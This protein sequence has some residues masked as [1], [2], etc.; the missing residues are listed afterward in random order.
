MCPHSARRLPNRGKNTRKPLYTHHAFT[1]AYRQDSTS[2]GSQ[3]ALPIPMSESETRRTWH[4]IARRTR[5]MINFAWWLDCFTPLLIVFSTLAAGIV[6]YL[7]STVGLFPAPWMGG[8]LGSSMLLFAVAT[9]FTVR[10]RFIHQHEVF[11]RLD[12][13]L[14]L[15]NALTTANQGVGPWPQPPAIPSIHCGLAWRWPRV[16]APFAISTALVLAAFLVPVSAIHKAALAAPSQPLAW[17]QMEDWLQSLDETALVEEPALDE[18]REKIEQLRDQPE[19]EWFSHSS[20]E[21]SDSLRDALAGQIQQLGSDLADTERNLDAFQNYSSQMTEGTKT[22]LLEEFSQAIKN[23]EAG[24]LPLDSHLM[25]ALKNI[26]PSQLKNLSQVSREQM[27]QLRRQLKKGAQ[28]CNKAG[29]GK[30]EGL[31]P[32][33]EGDRLA[34]L[35]EKNGMTVGRGGISRGPGEAPISLGDA[36][37][38]GTQNLETVHNPD[39]SRAAPGDVIAI[40]ESQHE[41]DKN[42]RGPQAA[43][44]VKST[45]RGGDTIW[46]ETLLPAEREL[47]KRYFKT[48]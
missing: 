28:A 9:W 44:A 24:S 45:G 32:L 25:E 38:L 33:G 46:R 26:D 47:L 12:D 27:D 20:M 43:G 35:M 34:Y 42:K 36:N 2:H 15:H 16:L 11:A 29:F 4:H 31:S 18:V 21:A 22:Q 5:A 13:R 39:L 41:I 1:L 30:Q 37:D 6:L 14:H 19:D 48:P 8:I 10:H 23:L 3:Q 7:R 40:G 17:Q